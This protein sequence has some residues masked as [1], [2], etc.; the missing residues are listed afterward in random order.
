M[1]GKVTNRV[2][3]CFVATEARQRRD[4]NSIYAAPEDYKRLNPAYRATAA[5]LR[6]ARC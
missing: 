2:I 5:S 3:L 4:E 6:W 1:A